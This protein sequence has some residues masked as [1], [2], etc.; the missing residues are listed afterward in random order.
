[1]AKIRICATCGTTGVPKTVTPGSILIEIIL[2]LFF[3]VPGLIYSI[4][5]HTKRHQAC[6]AC[7]GTSLLPPESPAARAALERFKAG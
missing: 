7:G 4:W 2:W 5:R 3:L 6:P 1:M